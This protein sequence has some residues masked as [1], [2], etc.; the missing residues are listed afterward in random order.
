MSAMNER[1]NCISMH[2]HV[3]FYVWIKHP[4]MYFYMWMK[5]PLI[6]VCG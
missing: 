5:R 2:P 3:N 1:M 6:A 4:P